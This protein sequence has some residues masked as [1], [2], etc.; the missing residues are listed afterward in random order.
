MTPSP[1]ASPL[2]H[3]TRNRRRKAPR[4]LTIWHAAALTLFILSLT[5]G[6]IAAVNL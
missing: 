2:I 5:A 1:F 4:N 6:I 3:A